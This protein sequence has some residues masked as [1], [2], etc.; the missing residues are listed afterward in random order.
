MQHILIVAGRGRYEDPWHDHA[1]TSHEVALLLAQLDDT[2]VTVRGLFLDA[3]DDLDRFD[4]LVVNAGSGRDDA[5]FDGD[6]AVWAPVHE[7][8]DTWAAVGGAVLG[9]HQAANTFADSRH[10]E[11]ILGGR[12][13]PG[14]S[15]HPPLDDV[16]IQVRRGVHP[17][18]AG[19]ADIAVRDERYTLLRPHPASLVL[20]THREAGADH[21]VAWVNEAEG[22]RTVYDALGHDVGALDSEG[23]RNLL[24]REAR[25]LLRRAVVEG[26]GR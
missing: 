9:L 3:L 2:S 1:G 8:L 19:L 21:P 4:L 5:A 18:V 10:W 16:T 14:E 20:A 22:Y 6:G 17:I 15:Y 24:R 13:V 23:R 26:D 25:W 12:W 11:R 7:R